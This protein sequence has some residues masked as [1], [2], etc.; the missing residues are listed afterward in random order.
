MTGNPVLPRILAVTAVALSLAAGTPAG[1]ESAPQAKSLI[2]K[3]CTNCHKAE[4]NT[5]RGYFDS[6]A[7]KARTI[8]VKIDDSVELVRFDEDEIK[9]VTAAG[10]AMDGEALRQTKKGQEIKIEYTEANGVKT[11]TR[12]IEKPPVAVSPGMLMATAEV[13]RLVALGPK[14][15]GYFLFDSR[16]L[17]RFREGSIP[18]AVSLPFVSFDKQAGELPANKNAL[19]IFYCSGPTCNMSPGSAAKARKLGYTN[20]KV[21]RDGIPAWSEKN[22]TVLSSQSLK[23]AWLDT[24][25]PHVLLDVRSPKEMGRG[26]ISGAVAF[27]AARFASLVKELPPAKRKPPIIVYDGPGAGQ[28][29]KVA[30]QLL[31]AGYGDVKVL[32][33]GFSGWRAAGYAAANGTPAA[34]AVYVAKPRPGEIDVAAFRK[35]AAELPPNVTIIDVRNADEVKKGMIAGAVNI[36]VEELRERASG[37]SKDKLLITQCSTGVRAEMAYHALK[38]LGF[39]SVGFLNATVTFGKDGSYTLST[40]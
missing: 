35:Y 1:A 18:T 9:V 7:F 30:R 25:T 6:V 27:P 17:P 32:Q 12:L 24:G 8:Q 34:R 14:K 3:I 39:P 23:E 13:E 33:G 10:K 40:P 22:Y 21:F 19:I 31:K 20:L 29:V 36:P 15:G 11:A 38:N 4:A 28:A 2:P 37:L 5:L 26:F 16:P